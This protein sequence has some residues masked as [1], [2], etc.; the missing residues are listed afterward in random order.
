VVA[1]SHVKLSP[2]LIFSTP[3]IKQLIFTQTNNIM[4]KDSWATAF[5]AAKAP[6][7][8]IT[9]DEVMKFYD[10]MDLTGDPKSFL[11]VDVRRED[12]EVSPF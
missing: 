5:P 9:C 4:E 10:D 1:C 3:R 8:D 11:L 2:P 7:V 12:W 6:P